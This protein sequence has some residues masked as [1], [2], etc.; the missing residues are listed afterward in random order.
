MSNTRVLQ[1][2]YQCALLPL[3]SCSCKSRTLDRAVAL[4]QTGRR[5][6]WYQP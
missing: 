2:Y 3:S 1:N 4:L 6:E 5:D